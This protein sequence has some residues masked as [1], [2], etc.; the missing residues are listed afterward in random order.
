MGAT[1]CN[2]WKKITR[3]RVIHMTDIYLKKTYILRDIGYLVF[4]QIEPFVL[5]QNPF[6]HPKAHMSRHIHSFYFSSGSPK[7][8]LTI[9]GPLSDFFFFFSY[10]W[11]KSVRYSNRTSR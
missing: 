9:S 7:L 10:G 5:Q 4:V 3:V 1:H 8:A 2:F 11:G 6:M